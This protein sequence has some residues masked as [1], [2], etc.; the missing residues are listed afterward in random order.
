[1]LTFCV[2]DTQT[3]SAQIRFPVSTTEYD[4]ALFTVWYA[5]PYYSFVAVN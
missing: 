3:T 4:I 5:R 2:C 1:M